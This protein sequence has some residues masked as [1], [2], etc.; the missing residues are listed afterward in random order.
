LQT[1]VTSISEHDDRE[2]LHGRLSMWRAFGGATARVALVVRLSLELGSNVALGTSLLPV[3]YFTDQDIVG[4]IGTVTANIRDNRDF[5][6]G[7]ERNVFIGT[8]FAMF[9]AAVVCLK[10]EGFHEER[11]WR[12][13][14]GPKRVPSTLIESSV[15]VIAGIPQLV[16]KIPLENNSG[17]G[18]SG[19]D[20]SDLVDR[21]IIGPSQFQWAMYEAFVTALDAAGVKN[22]ASRVF[23]SQIPVRT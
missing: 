21:I 20:P 16:Y 11:E 3:S 13:I 15:E 9:A 23:V 4:E 1:Y 10:H 8:V 22:A 14:Y 12:V 2:D 18:I 6:R 17:A 5:L 7:L 19:L